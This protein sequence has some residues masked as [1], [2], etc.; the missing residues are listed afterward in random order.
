MGND[1]LREP[2]LHGS[3]IS[4]FSLLIENAAHDTPMYKHTHPSCFS[5]TVG[6]IS[7]LFLAVARVKLS[8]GFHVALLR[9]VTSSGLRRIGQSTVS[10]N[11]TVQ[12]RAL[13]HHLVDLLKR[14][15]S[16]LRHEEVGPEDT[17]GAKAAPDEEHLGAEVAVCRVDHVGHDDSYR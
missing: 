2:A 16:R 15:T 13:T 8:C 4:P 5:D 1:I 7:S 6:S 11:V 12:S 10:S 17:A 9:A 3:D 14:Q